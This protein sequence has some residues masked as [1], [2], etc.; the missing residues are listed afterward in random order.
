MKS[1]LYQQAKRETRDSLF[2][3]PILDCAASDIIGKQFGAK[4]YP[5]APDQALCL[6]RTHRSDVIT[7]DMLGKFRTDILFFLF[8]SHS[9]EKVLGNMDF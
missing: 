9:I 8:L 3:L 6:L 7:S 2:P 5:P 4:Y 1:C